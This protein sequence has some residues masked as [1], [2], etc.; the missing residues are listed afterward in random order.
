MMRDKEGPMVWKD[1]LAFI[2]D[3]QAPLPSGAPG[4]PTAPTASGAG[5]GQA[6]AGK[7]AGS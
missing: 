6:P 4:I 5:P 1:I 3:P 2:R 7:P